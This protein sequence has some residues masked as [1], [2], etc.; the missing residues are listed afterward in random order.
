MLENK[1]EY[2]FIELKTDKKRH[3]GITKQSSSEDTNGSK[4]IGG[5]ERFAQTADDIFNRKEKKKK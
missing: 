4:Q 5:F 3:N 2:S 1:K